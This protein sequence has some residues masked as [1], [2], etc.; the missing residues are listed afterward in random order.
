MHE[1]HLFRREDG[2]GAISFGE[3]RG[4]V[5]SD[6]SVPVVQMPCVG[7]SDFRS[8]FRHRMAFGESDAG[9][10]VLRF[11]LEVFDILLVRFTEH[12]LVGL[13]LG[14]ELASTVLIEERGVFCF[15]WV[16]D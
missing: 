13:S 1:C 11:G 4:E 7:V 10:Q 5:S 8:H 16:W 9:F 12:Q 2:K 14:F 3:D 15:W 6:S